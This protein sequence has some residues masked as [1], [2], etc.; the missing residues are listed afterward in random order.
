MSHEQREVGE[1]SVQVDSRLTD[2]AL[3]LL[4]ESGWGGLTQERIAERAGISRVTAWRQGATRDAV[5]ATLLDRLGAD[6]REAM[7][8]VLTGHGTGAER[9]RAGLER[10]CDVA[11]RHLPLLLASDRAF[12]R[13]FREEHGSAGIDFV[14]PFARF[15]VDGV[16]DGSLRSLSETPLE[17]AEIV[18]NTVCWTYVHLRGSHE[19]PPEK[20]RSLVIDLVMRGL[21]T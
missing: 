20:A 10:L 5:I 2:A 12:H 7:W 17:G 9:L 14:D 16:A 13:G 15:I 1:A 6:Y 21:S 18:F 11:D 4:A 3:A 8:A 19:W